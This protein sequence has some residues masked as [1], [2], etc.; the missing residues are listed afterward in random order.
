MLAGW[1]PRDTRVRIAFCED[2]YHS[3]YGAQQ[4]LVNLAKNLP[5]DGFFARVLT[6][7]E[8]LF[9][10]RCRAAGLECEILP[11]G[12]V[13]NRYGGEVLRYGTRDKLR[14]G[15]ELGLY[16]ASFWRWL[17]RERIEIV[18][19]N[20]SRLS[21]ALG[22]AARAAGVPMLVFLQGEGTMPWLNSASL[23]LCRRMLLIA[24]ALRAEFSPALL[25][26]HGDKLRTLNT[27]FRFEPVEAA[28]ER[29][30]LLRR[31]WGLAENAY[32]I[33]LVG[34]IS[35]RKGADIL[36]A[37][38]PRILSAIPDAHFVL[39]GHA[40]LGQEQF[41][42][43]LERRVRQLGL[44]SR[45]TITG[46]QDDMAA[47]YGALDLCVLPSRSEGLP[48]VTIESMGY[49]LPC[50]A[51]RVGGTEDV[52]DDPRFGRVV[53]PEDAEAIAAA[54]ERLWRDEPRDG[55]RARERSIRTRAAFSTERYVETFV[56][57]VREFVPRAIYEPSSPTAADSAEDPVAAD[58]RHGDSAVNPKPGN[59]KPGNGR[60]ANDT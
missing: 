36:A 15:A 19:C 47:A 53:P 34:S 17:R 14:T 28:A 11:M 30:R 46:F 38:A 33:G 23:V 7:K 5:V 10:A 51:T 45:W 26:V 20:S 52:I 18:V 31:R 48:G 44:E 58:H 8:G 12:D 37:A 40:P 9:A 55:S 60:A 21:L 6:T 56:R 42:R 22:T 13:A 24:S 29:G 25:R 43:E 4:N 49:G 41:A 3:F 2:R 27:G 59:H 35:E 16:N 50:V 57:I 54:I 1:D 39:V 32:A